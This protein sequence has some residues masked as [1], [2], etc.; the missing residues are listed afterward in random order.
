MLFP[1]ASAAIDAFLDASAA[2]DAFLSSAM[3]LV[4]YTIGCALLFSLLVLV[5]CLGILLFGDIV[6]SSFRHY[7]RNLPGL[8]TFRKNRGKGKTKT[9][10]PPPTPDPLLT[11]M[12]V[13]AMNSKEAQK[14]ADKMENRAKELAERIKNSEAGVHPAVPRE[15][16]LVLDAAGFRC[17]VAVGALLV[18]SHF[19]SAKVSLKEKPSLKEKEGAAAERSIG[20]SKAVLKVRR[21]VGSSGGAHVA[22]MFAVANEVGDVQAKRDAITFVFAWRSVRDHVAGDPPRMRE[23]LRRGGAA[24]L[25]HAVQSCLHKPHAES[26]RQLASGKCLFQ[27]MALP[28]ASLPSASSTT[29]ASTKEQF[30]WRGF[31][32]EYLDVSGASESGVHSDCVS[33]AM[34]TGAILFACTLGPFFTRYKNLKCWDAG[35]F[36]GRVP[37]PS[38]PIVTSSATT[39]STTPNITAAA[40]EGD[41][42]DPIPQL[43]LHTRFFRD[44]DVGYAPL[45]LW[46]MWGP[47]MHMQER[48]ILHGMDVMAQYLVSGSLSGQPEFDAKLE[49]R[50]YGEKTRVGSGMDLFM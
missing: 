47:S 14:L 4:L 34:A 25:V 6:L 27:V 15:F 23:M 40:G 44:E 3:W 19:L 26:Y 39:T 38:S 41:R 45:A 48:A 35:A 46:S 22:G 16:D 10:S 5:T 42:A 2:I 33:A 28:A 11:K 8:S 17:Q 43:V 37:D 30:S 13:A 9:A 12:C 36:C 31:R 7:C 20:S 1:D 50:H 24:D 21:Y 29:N 49:L 18:L 32:S